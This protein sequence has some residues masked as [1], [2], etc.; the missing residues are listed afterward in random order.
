VRDAPRDRSKLS[1]LSGSLK[2]AI[3]SCKTPTTES[4][5]HVGSGKSLF[6]PIREFPREADFSKL[7][8]ILT[9]KLGLEVGDF[10]RVKGLPT[11]PASSVKGNIR[12]RLE[13]S[14]RAVNGRVRACFIRASRP[15]PA[16]IFWRHKKI[17]S[18]VL[19]E[20]R[21]DACDLTE[22]DKVCLLCDLFGTAGLS[23]LIS[24]EDFVGKDVE[25][26][27]IKV[28]G[29]RI[30]AAPP[31]SEFEGQIHFTNLLEEELGLLLLGM[32][33]K[34]SVRGR[35]L[36]LGRLK[37]R[38][39]VGSL[40]MGRVTY[41]VKSLQLSKYSRRIAGFDSRSF[42][43]ENE[44]TPLIQSL[45]ASTLKKYGAEFIVVDEVSRLA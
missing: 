12:A 23:S 41:V 30:L 35:P 34:D 36:L 6:E 37:Y 24:F 42:E 28:D 45:T 18:D 10:A 4:Y 21:G 31:G 16:G 2:V 25:L 5:L 29:M 26:K 13:L 33:L 11:I 3:V 1:D 15:P 38:G 32:G 40:L 43:G 44:L 22:A 17:W 27:E 7:V 39:R 20:D 19:N 14:F 8:E 9:Q